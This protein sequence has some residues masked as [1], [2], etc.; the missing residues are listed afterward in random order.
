MLDQI[1]ETYIQRIKSTVITDAQM[2][3]IPLAYVSRLN[4][5]ESVK[6]FLDQQVEIWLREEE[7]KFQSSDRFDYDRP[8]VRMLIDQIFDFLKQNANFH[9]TKF[10]HLIERAIKLE[11]NYLIEPHRTLRQFI[12]KDSEVVSTL[13]VYDT[14]KYFSHFTYY[15]AA[16]SE[17]FDTK[18]M[19][20]VSE[21]QFVN[22]M[23]QI[24][25][26]TF[27]A[28]PVEMALRM[29]KN[30]VTFFSQATEKEVDTIAL[31]ILETAF[32]DRDL[33]QF[34]EKIQQVKTKTTLSELHFNEVEAL[35][36]DGVIPGLKEE[37][38]RDRTEILGL[39]KVESLEQHKPAV[40]V[41]DIEVGEMVVRPQEAEEAEEEY[42]EEETGA[43]VATALADFVASQISSD[44]PLQ[45]INELITGRSRRKIIKKLF[46]KK[47]K[48]FLEF[49]VQLNP[50]S[51]WKEASPMIDEVFYERNIN[52]YSNEAIMFSDL[53]YN[54]FFPKDKYVGERGS[55][56]R[57]F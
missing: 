49:I 19:R 18:F 13:E 28:E 46:N 11:I 39:E 15:K 22:L 20:Q 50:V 9:V 55:S 7:Q 12:F 44:T 45:D 17:Y 35:L 24:D 16:V 30:I 14:F 8:E 2:V 27:E 10:N 33:R 37:E 54:R 4:I 42:E 1:V 25:Q 51:S 52:P 34:S 32:K 6:H 38:P 53:V 5:S 29:V 36:R 31:E 57:F 23:Q 48:E 40:A 56:N 3:D 26:K 41:K 21:N 43:S 47:E